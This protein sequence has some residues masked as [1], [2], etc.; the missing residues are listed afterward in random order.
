MS[1]CYTVF[2]IIKLYESLFQDE[3]DRWLECGMQANVTQCRCLDSIQ[4]D[5]ALLLGSPRYKYGCSFECFDP[6]IVHMYAPNNKVADH[7]EIVWC[8]YTKSSKFVKPRRN[9][10]EVIKDAFKEEILNLSDDMCILLFSLL[11]LYKVNIAVERDVFIEFLF[12]RY[13]QAFTAY[14]E[15][16][17]IALSNSAY[18]GNIPKHI[19]MISQILTWF[20]HP[21][22]ERDEDYQCLKAFLLVPIGE[23]IIRADENNSSQKRENLR[24]LLC[25]KCLEPLKQNC[26]SPYQVKDSISNIF[27]ALKAKNII[28]NNGGVH[29]N[30]KS[31]IN[32]IKQMAVNTNCQGDSSI[33]KAIDELNNLII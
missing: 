18:V 33:K 31:I 25:G 5:L 12:I 32:S 6:Y 4:L 9:G 29:M 10:R 28:A 15:S 2:D 26:L 24:S 19:E 7:K 8:K 30:C 16:L 23:G 3:Y 14:L 22:D 11:C 13:P 20:S 21:V 27:R 17:S 1:S